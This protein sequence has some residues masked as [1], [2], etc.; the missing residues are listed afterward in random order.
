M[1]IREMIEEREKLTIPYERSWSVNSLGRDTQEEESDMRTCYMRDR[2]R[3]IH[4]KSFRRMKH[5]T[6]VFLAPE[7][8]HYRTR[9][10]HT[11]EVAQI[12]RSIARALS[13]N[14]DLTEAIALGHD[15]GHTPFGH[16]G[17]RSLDKLCPYHFSHYTQCIR[18]VEKLENGRGLNLTKEVRD[19]MKN[20]SMKSMPSTNEGRIVRF[21]DKIAY[22]NHDIDDAV[23]ARILSEDDLPLEARKV[24]GF[25][26]RDR[27]N[28]L[29][30]DVINSSLGKDTVAMSDEVQ[31]AMMELRQAMFDEVYNI[32]SEA[33]TEERKA[34]EMIESLYHRLLEDP[35]K[36]LPEFYVGRLKENLDPAEV[37]V[38]DYIASMSDNYAMRIYSDIFM[39]KGWNLV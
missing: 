34:Q 30:H 32:G 17:E 26:F 13:F 33:K 29:V 14:E 2:D 3:I 12:A 39:P 23:R 7:G 15:I 28:T 16:A 9:L 6:Q 21:S 36:Y 35:E 38:C 8:D 1:N 25:S 37:L 19:G 10:T 5:K 4:C 24:L 27:I 11:L 20:H 31:D 18:I 22:I